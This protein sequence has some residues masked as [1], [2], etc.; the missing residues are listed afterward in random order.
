MLGIYGFKVI[1]C[2]IQICSQTIFVVKK[3][4]EILQIKIWQGFMVFSFLNEIFS[5][6]NLFF[7]IYLHFKC[8]SYSSSDSQGIHSRTPE[9]WRNRKIWLVI[10][11]PT[12]WFH[13]KIGQ[14]FF[15]FFKKL[16]TFFIK[17]KLKILTL[18]NQPNV[19]I[20][21]KNSCWSK[22]EV[23]NSLQCNL[24]S[25]DKYLERN[26]YEK[27]IDWCPSFYHFQRPIRFV[28]YAFSLNFYQL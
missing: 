24:L 23:D 28:Y 25:N 2:S 15:C 16:N 10:F 5:G 11:Q 13:V 8:R 22:F 6:K 17:L 3:L 9:V 26:M 20:P 18:F 12:K 4:K 7:S 14:N 19:C 27:I 21:Q 1:K